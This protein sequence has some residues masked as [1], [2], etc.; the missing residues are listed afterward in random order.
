M[1][2]ILVILLNYSDAFDTI[3]HAVLFRR[4]QNNYSLMTVDALEWLNSYNSHQA[5]S[6][7]SVNSEQHDLTY[8]MPQGSIIWHFGYPRYTSPIARVTEKREVK[9]Q[10]YTNDTQLY[11]AGGADDAN[12]CKDPLEWC[13]EEVRSW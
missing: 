7:N 8:G 13:I 12:S 9:Y 3:D 4:L 5:V 2:H 6:I 10:Q 1:K 11:V